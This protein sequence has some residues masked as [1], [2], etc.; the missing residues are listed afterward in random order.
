MLNVHEIY[1]QYKMLDCLQYELLTKKHFPS[2][3]VIL[4]FWIVGFIKQFFCLK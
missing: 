4:L 3:F 2:S 1:L